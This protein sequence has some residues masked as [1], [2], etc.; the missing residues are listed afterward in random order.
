MSFPRSIALLVLASLTALLLFW[1]LGAVYLWQDEAQTAVLGERLFQYGRP[2]AYDG[3]NLLT[4]DSFSD[5]DP[6]T[7]DSRTGDADAE[8][9]HLVSRGDFKPDGT[10]VGHPWGQFAVAGMSLWILGHGTAAARIPF[11]VAALLTVLLLHGMVRRVFGSE[12]L[13]LLASAILVG[14]A[15]WL[16]HMRQARYYALSTLFLLL[17]VWAFVRWR[18]ARPWGAALFVLSG[19]TYFQC[20][21][22]SFFPALAALLAVALAPSDR[23]PLATLATFGLLAVAV[24]PFAWYYDLHRRMRNPTLPWD[25]R[26]MGNLGN[27]DLHILP[28]VVL[29]AAAWLQWRRRTDLST[30]QRDLLRASTGAIV[31]MI[32]WVPAITAYPFH[33]YVV[34]LTPLGALLAAW[35]VDDVARAAALRW[36]GRRT[37]TVVTVGLAALLVATPLLSVSMQAG[38]G[39]PVAP[40]DRVLRAEIGVTLREIFRER[41]D[42][43]RLVIEWLRPRLAP[44]DEILANYEDIPLMFYTGARIRGG[45]AA[46]RVEDRS[47]PPARFMVIRRSVPF[48]HWP[49][50][51]REVRRHSSIKVATGA[52]DVPF[53]NIPDPAF[54]AGIGSGPEVIVAER[55]GP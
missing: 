42:P 30:A 29:V 15:V 38:I 55:A 20:D 18:Q 40:L 8:L 24:A 43:N 2:L 33:R 22:G 12:R 13:A 10:W 25:A 36:G 53:G 46:F 37:R 28:L 9:R 48:V 35:V 52:P 26:F 44:G 47:S 32:P 14:N 5:E 3:R 11:A 21:Y 16:L 6:G 31:A 4:I 27:L 41:P 45:V 19:F 17:T 23:R 1:R 50:F 54:L 51:L 49:V 7:I 39:G 34:Q